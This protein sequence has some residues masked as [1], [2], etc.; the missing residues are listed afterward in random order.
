MTFVWEK[1]VL[2]ELLL[3]NKE[4]WININ[5]CKSENNNICIVKWGPCELS[6]LRYV[7]VWHLHCCCCWCCCCWAC[8]MRVSVD[9]FNQ[10]KFHIWKLW[11]KKLKKK[12]KK[13]SY[14]RWGVYNSLHWQISL[15]ELLKKTTQAMKKFSSVNLTCTKQSNTCQQTLTIIQQ[16]FQRLKAQPWKE[17]KKVMSWVKLIL[18]SYDLV[19]Y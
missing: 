10:E 11:V 17:R 14:I 9:I 15:S 2:S 19:A 16:P 13:K 6:A 8:C 5:I 18:R 3:I 12:R 4:N 7:S 1:S